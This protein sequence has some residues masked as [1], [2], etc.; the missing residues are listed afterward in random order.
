MCINE[1]EARGLMAE[2]IYRICGC[3]EDIEKLKTTF[4]QGTLFNL[5]VH[6]IS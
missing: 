6:M 5:C 4:E 1:L 3:V 2:G